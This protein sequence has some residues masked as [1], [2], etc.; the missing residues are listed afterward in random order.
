MIYEV[1][2]RYVG[3]QESTATNAGKKRFF[4][5]IADGSVPESQSKDCEGGGPD[6]VKQLDAEEK[7]DA[8]TVTI[9]DIDVIV[10]GKNP[11]HSS[12]L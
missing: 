11:Q 5:R 3:S 12:L 2:M 7:K 1:W 6:N 4:T 9:R 8:D 10:D